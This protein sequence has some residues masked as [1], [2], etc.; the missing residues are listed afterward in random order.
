MTEIIEQ[1]AA[2]NNAVRRAGKSYTKHVP[3][4]GHEWQLNSMIED[5]VTIAK[6]EGLTKQELIEWVDKVFGEISI[7]IL[8]LE[9]NVTKEF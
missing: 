9:E 4:V 6:M 3:G 5:L 8:F 2:M 7:K 1:G